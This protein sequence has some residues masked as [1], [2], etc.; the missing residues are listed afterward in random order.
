MEEPDGEFV[1]K[2]ALLDQILTEQFALKNIAITLMSTIPLSVPFPSKREEIGLFTAKIPKIP[3]LST[4]D[5]L[6]SIGT[7]FATFARKH[8]N[9]EFPDTLE[10][11]NVN[12]FKKTFFFP[13]QV[14]IDYYFN[15]A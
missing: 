14:E 6:N 11:E 1:S 4:L 8:A 10:F 15:F 9:E 7:E 12:V 5:C 3:T 13:E 2:C